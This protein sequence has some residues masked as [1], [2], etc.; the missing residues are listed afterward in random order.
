[1]QI[2]LIIMCFD[3]MSGQVRLVAELCIVTYFADEFDSTQI[4]GKQKAAAVGSQ[5]SWL[6]PCGE[7]NQALE[8][9]HILTMFIGCYSGHHFQPETLTF[10]TN[11]EPV[12]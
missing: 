8:S 4:G 2:Y 1:M 7:F 12:S 11:Q 10:Q 3:L 5:F 9:G 6:H